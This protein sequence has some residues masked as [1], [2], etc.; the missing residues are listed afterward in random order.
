MP[1]DVLWTPSPERVATTNLARFKQRVREKYAPNLGDRYAD[2]HRWSLAHRG[3]FWR[4]LWVFCDVIGDPGETAYIPGDIRSVRWFPEARLN[5]AEN[6]LHES[7]LADPNFHDAV[8]IRCHSEDESCD[9]WNQVVTWG[10]L[11]EQVRNCVGFLRRA[12]VAAGDCVAGIL[13]NTP[14]A[15]V[16]ML[17]T[18]ALGGV[19]ACCSP[20]FG[21]DAI[22]ERFGP[23]NPKVLFAVSETSYAGKRVDVGGKAETVHQRLGGWRTLSLLDYAPAFY[24]SDCPFDRFAFDQPAFVLFSSGTTGPPKGIVHGAGGTLLQHLKEHQLHCDIGTGDT[25]F[26]HT[27]TGWMMWNWLVSALA[28]KATIVLYDGS[29]V[30]PDPAVLWRMAAALKVTHFGAGA[31]YYAAIAK[32]AVR[33][34]DHDLSALRCVL[35]TGSPLLPDQFDWV[36]QHVK[37]DVHLAS[38]SGGSDIVSCFVLGV[39][40][41]PVRRGEIQAAGLGMDVQVWDDAG[42]RVVGE[43]GELVCASPFPSRPVGFWDDPDGAKYQAAYFDRFPG[44]WTHGDWATETDT[45]GFV[46]HGR[47]D[48]TLNPGGVR[49]GTAD[50]YRQ[51]EAFPDVA[52]ALAVPLRQDG[53]E[54]I[55]LFVRMQTGR[56]LT[57]ELVADIK[58]RLRANCSPRHVPAF[59]VGAADFPRTVSGKLSEV[60]V[61]NAV[62]GQPVRNEAAL[63]NPAALGFFREWGRAAA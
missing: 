2:L 47:S 26:F 34:A 8:A 15:V 60:A 45:G 42:N 48:T 43:P 51:V 54:R 44:V 36:Y 59:V 7:R 35:S 1:A 56:E 40:T 39:P 9:I 17:A 58:G 37:P 25:V 57:P 33:P 4:A 3:D 5:F 50:L 46:I 11:A 55:V 13:P 14:I 21:V 61:R 24:P 52:E 18:T 20:D 41:E 10:Q 23:L 62:N 29:P 49:I 6:L 22:L 12:G 32:A 38:I 28:S 30:H 53:D 31:R 19:W 16:A 63:A 27:T